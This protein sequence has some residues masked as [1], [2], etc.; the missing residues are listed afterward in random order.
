MR[1]I[2][3]KSG[4]GQE[5]RANTVLNQCFRDRF[6]AA[7]TPDEHY[8]HDCRAPVNEGRKANVLSRSQSWRHVD[9]PT[10]RSGEDY[11]F[12]WN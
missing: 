6:F 3:D 1:Q 9:V 12:C 5:I 7:N 11:P 8:E 10:I 4:Q 2:S